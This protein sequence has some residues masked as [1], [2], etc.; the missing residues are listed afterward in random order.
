[1]RAAVGA[2]T[3]RND[4]EDTGFFLL[5]RRVACPAHDCPVVHLRHGRVG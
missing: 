4:M 3:C 1:M 2:I 5:A